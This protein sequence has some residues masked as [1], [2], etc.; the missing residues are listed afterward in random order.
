MPIFEI[1]VDGID[2][3]FEVE[4]ADAEEA[5]RGM[6][7]ENVPKYPAQ[8]DWEVMV[9]SPIAAKFKCKVVGI[10]DIEGGNAIETNVSV[11]RVG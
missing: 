8:I 2:E 1:R 3:I 10:K 4:A 11:E 7:Q 9:I 5:V 6:I